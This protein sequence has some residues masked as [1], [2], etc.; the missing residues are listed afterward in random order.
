MEG[1]QTFKSGP[2]VSVSG[3]R[4]YI[5]ELDRM[6]V[7]DGVT[8]FRDGAKYGGKSKFFPQTKD[9]N[10]EKGWFENAEYKKEGK[11]GWVPEIN[12]VEVSWHCAFT[13]RHVSLVHVLTRAL[14]PVHVICNT[15]FGRVDSLQIRGES[16]QRKMDVLSTNKGYEFRRRIV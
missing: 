14:R 11:W 8:T 12:D 9:L 7:L 6:E 1:T 4:G 16:F 13:K 10:L 2:I 15:A 5:P 3:K